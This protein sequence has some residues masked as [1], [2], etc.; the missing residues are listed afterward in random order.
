[1]E[2][3][4][5]I[6]YDQFPLF[7]Q[8]VAISVQPAQKGKLTLTKKL[9][10]YTISGKN[11]SVQFDFS[12]ASMTA[13]KYRGQSIIVNGPEPSF[14]RAPTDNDIGAG[15]N[16]K[17]RMWRN[18]Y[19]SGKVLNASATQNGDGSYEVKF[20]KS[21]LD[22]DAV[23]TQIF[24]VYSDG[25]IKVENQFNAVKGKYPLMMRIGNDLQLLK[26]FDRI[27]WYGRGPWEN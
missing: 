15:F 7:R 26:Q 16:K 19:Q 5:E 6:A 22:G 10:Q 4:Y 14:W 2:K 9:D 23:V 12:T 11:F 18:A 25:K 17:L 27:E 20:E 21:L 1:L 3:G 24:S 8:P 13:Y